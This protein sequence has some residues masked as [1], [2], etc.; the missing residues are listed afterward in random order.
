[1]PMALADRESLALV[2]TSFSIATAGQARSQLGLI[3]STQG[4]PTAHDVTSRDTTGV[5]WARKAAG[6]R[7]NG[8]SERSTPMGAKRSQESGAVQ[9]LRFAPIFAAGRSNWR[10]RT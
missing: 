9:A 7:R 4:A 10:P 2:A 6:L 1:M 8:D 3:R 5:T